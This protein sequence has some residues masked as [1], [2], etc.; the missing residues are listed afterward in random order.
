MIKEE[1]Y[2]QIKKSEKIEELITISFKFSCDQDITGDDQIALLAE[3]T[4]RLTE[5]G[6]L[7]EEERKESLDFLIKAS[8]MYDDI[9]ETG[10][11]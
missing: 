6:I 11:K 4:E 5:L 1:Y 10:K 7:D 3:T 8:D 2:S 9:D